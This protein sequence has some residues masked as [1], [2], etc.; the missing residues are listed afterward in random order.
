MDGLT[1]FLLGVIITILSSH[2]FQEY[3]KKKKRVISWYEYSRALK[4]KELLALFED[5]NTRPDIL[6]GL[7]DGIV[8][9]AILA[10]NFG[11]EEIYY[12]HIFPIYDDHGERIHPK[13]KLNNLDLR[14]KLVLIVDDQAYSGRSMEALY[15]HLQTMDANE[16]TQILRFVLFKHD[17]PGVGPC[18]DIT[19]SKEIKGSLK[20]V[21]WF[22]CA[23]H[24]KLSNHTS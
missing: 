16:N 1:Y 6:I 13:I 19:C 12:T 20:S 8:T 21:P 7:N 4:N 15:N 18:A 22:L 14:D 23:V 9:A 3:I 5:E 11:I 2:W 24:K 10:T 17:S